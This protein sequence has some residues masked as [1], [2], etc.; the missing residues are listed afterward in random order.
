MPIISDS[1]ENVV[2]VVLVQR[3]GTAAAAAAAKTVVHMFHPKIG[4]EK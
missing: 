4:P 3:D 2:P 1:C